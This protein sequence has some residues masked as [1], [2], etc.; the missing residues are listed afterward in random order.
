[1]R[2]KV[3]YPGSPFIIQR[4]LRDRDKFKLFE[5]HPTDTKTLA[6]NVAQLESGRQVAQHLEDGS[7]ASALAFPRARPVLCDPSYEMKND[8][9]RCSTWSLI[10]CSVL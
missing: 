9:A 8:F 4:L 1:M 5:L 7:E 3:S 6:A 2:A 10:R